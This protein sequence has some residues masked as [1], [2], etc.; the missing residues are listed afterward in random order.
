LHGSYRSVL[1]GRTR[2][3]KKSDLTRIGRDEAKLKGKIAVSRGRSV[4]RRAVK[5][6]AKTLETMQNTL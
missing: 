5:I 6:Q 4:F 3:Q 1:R 2:S